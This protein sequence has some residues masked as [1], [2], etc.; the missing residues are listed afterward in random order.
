MQLYDLYTEVFMHKNV[1]HIIEMLIGAILI[2]LGLLYLSSQYR[3]LSRLTDV[4]S[5]ETIK[6]NNVLQQYNNTDILQVTDK[7]VYAAII[8]YREYPMMVDAVYLIP[9]IGKDYGL[10]FS[11]VR[12]GN[13]KKDYRYDADRNII[14]I[15]F[16]YQGI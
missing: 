3:T 13:Y 9:L 8:G 5:Q 14:M 16:T 6:D 2:G 1:T 11:Y 10:Y 7:D 12:N 4:M 15:L